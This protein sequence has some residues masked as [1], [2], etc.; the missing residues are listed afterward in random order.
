MNERGLILVNTGN[1]KGKT[2]AALGV[3]LRAV[4]Q[5]FKVLI[6]QF[7]KSGNGY[8]ELAGLA[9]LGDQVEIRSMGKGFIYYKRDEVGEAE[10]ARHKE[11]AQAAWR[12]LVEEVNSDKWDL[13]VMDEINNAINYELID[14]H[15]EVEMLNNKPKRLHVVLTGRYAKPEIIDMADT[16]TEMKVVKHAYEKGIKAAKGIEF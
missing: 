7:I 6:L 1:G 9:K 2:T 13:I 12:T 15:S 10:L 5:G 4:G 3:V 8:G 11:A 14:V 16:V